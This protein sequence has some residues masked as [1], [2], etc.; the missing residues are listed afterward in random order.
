MSAS[1]RLSLALAT[2]RVASRWWIAISLLSRAVARTSISA[3][4]SL[5]KSR[6]R[7]WPALTRSPGR[8]R[9]S[10]IKPTLELTPTGVAR[11]YSMEHF[12]SRMTAEGEVVSSAIADAPRMTGASSR[13]PRITGVRRMCRSSRM[14]RGGPAGQLLA[15]ARSGLTIR[16]GSER[17]S[18]RHTRSGTRGSQIRYDRSPGVATAPRSSEADLRPGSIATRGRIDARRTCNESCSRTHY[19]SCSRPLQD[20]C[21]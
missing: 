6:P 9:H 1:V 4:T 21:R 10:W 3:R 5:L 20:E 8:T 13:S 17:C 11:S 15:R 14:M 19:E 16:P 12:C 7:T 18:R 2:S